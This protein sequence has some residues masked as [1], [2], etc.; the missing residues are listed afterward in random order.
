M[1]RCGCS[2]GVGWGAM[3]G[4]PATLWVIFLMVRFGAVLGWLIYVG[5]LALLLLAVVIRGM[6]QQKA[7]ERRMAEITRPRSERV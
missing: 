6:R 1:N 5:L 4:L 3:V 7:Y 2:E